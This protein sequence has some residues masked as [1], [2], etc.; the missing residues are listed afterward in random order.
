MKLKVGDI[1][2]PPDHIREVFEWWDS[3]L[4]F[5]VKKRQY[6]ELYVTA[7]NGDAYDIDV[8]RL[9]GYIDSGSRNCF[10]LVRKPLLTENE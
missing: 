6:G 10:K 8:L 3:K 7:L 5:V 4:G 2:I 9:H 1:L